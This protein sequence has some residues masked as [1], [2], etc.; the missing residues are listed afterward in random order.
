MTDA[1]SGLAVR[2]QNDDQPAPQQL[3]AESAFGEMYTDATGDALTMAS[4]A[5]AKPVANGAAGFNSAGLAT[6]ESNDVTLSIADGTF[7]VARGG[8]YLLEFNGTVVS[9]DAEE[10]I[11]F[12]W[13]KNGTNLGEPAEA[14]LAMPAAAAALLNQHVSH[15]CIVAL[16]PGDAVRLTVLGQ[17]DQAIT[18]QRFNLRVRLLKSQSYGR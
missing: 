18:L 15:A 11:T 8:T 13:Q 2:T 4:T 14:F 16:S 1:A 17:D 7:T 3:Y 9:G 10:D 6:G 5:A 12:E